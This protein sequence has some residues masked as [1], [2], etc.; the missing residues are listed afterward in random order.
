MSQ[1]ALER[2][3]A[4]LGPAVIE[5]H[6][7]RGDETA[8]LDRAAVHRA[9]LWL[10]DTDGLNF[11]LL[12]DLTAVDYLEQA[13][14]YRFEVVY[15]LYSMKRRHRLRLKTRVQL[16][17]PTVDTVSDLWKVANWLEREVWDM[18][19]IRFNGHPDPRRILLYEEFVG[20]PLRKDYPKERRQ[21]LARRPPEEIAA[22]LAGRPG[23]GRSLLDP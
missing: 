7:H 6:Q 16:E 10:R 15:H 22:A 8:L 21:P 3:V 5:T 4:E 9:C 20:H 13:R 1:M 23:T 17:D 12:T 2:L 14:A 18:Y 19:G 11:D